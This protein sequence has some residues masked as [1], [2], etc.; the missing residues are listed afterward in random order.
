MLADQTR[1]SPGRGKTPVSSR[2]QATIRASALWA[3][4]TFLWV[5]WR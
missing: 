1:W 2:R 5:A 4:L 3:L